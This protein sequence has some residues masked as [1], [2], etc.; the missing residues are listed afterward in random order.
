[1]ARKTDAPKTPAAL[2]RRILAARRDAITAAPLEPS[3]ILDAT[4]AR[5][6]GGVVRDSDRNDAGWGNIMMGLADMA[7]DKRE[8]HT[9]LSERHTYGELMELYRGNDLAARI[10]DRPAEDMTREGFE[11]SIDGEEQMGDDVDGAADEL[12]LL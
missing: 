11:T 10:A 7:R 1:M 4:G 5:I 2:D 9:P 12:Q 3:R 8:Y 6:P